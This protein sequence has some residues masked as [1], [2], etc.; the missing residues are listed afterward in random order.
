VIKSRG[1]PTTQPRGGAAAPAISL[2]HLSKRFGATHALSDVS[3]SIAHGEI[4]ALVGENGAGKST[5]GKI[6][7]GVYRPDSGGLQVLGKSVTGW[8]TRAALAGGVAMI[9]QELSLVPEMTVAENVFL[10]RETH[11]LGLLRNDLGEQ[12]AELDARVGFGLSAD[13]RVTNLRIADQQKVEILRALARDARVIIMDEPTSSLTA[14]ETDRLHVIIQAL[15][16]QGRTIVYVT[17]FLEHVLDKSDR[18]SV[19]RDGHLVRTARSADESKAS[20]VEAMLGR[21]LDL[22]F[23]AKSPIP[24][25]ARPALELRDVECGASVK[26][27]S[28]HVRHGEIVGLAGLV[29]S[30]RSEIA[31]AVFGADPLTG[32]EILIEGSPYRRASPRRSVRQKVALIPEDRRRQGLVMSERVGRNIS[33]PHLR[34]MSRLGFV[35]SRLEHRLARTMIARLKIHP[36]RAEHQVAA[37]SGGNQQKVLFAKWMAGNPRVVLLDEP[38]RGVDVGAKRQLYEVVTELAK[39]GAAVLIISSDLEEVIG[40]AHRI[41]LVREGR[42]IG[43]A[44]AEET[45]VDDVLFRLFGIEGNNHRRETS[46]AV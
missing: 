30:G 44:V 29:G 43:D 33:L 11:R 39:S 45:S 13:S 18:V 38:T 2:Q 35:I 37:L 32:G 46:E 27:V 1:G 40:L 14:D 41:Y 9:Q 12:Y 4:H 26:G 10:G 31:R 36:P 16:D 20:L 34:L 21:P 42:I 24:P 22:T 19:M 25:D 28:L 15:R 5:L 17:H 7:G 6:V 23:P 8:D 3:L